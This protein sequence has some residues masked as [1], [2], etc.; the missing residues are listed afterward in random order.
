LRLSPDQLR[1]KIERPVNLQPREGTVRGVSACVFATVVAQSSVGVSGQGEIKHTSAGL[2]T[3]AHQVRQFRSPLLRP[4]PARPTHSAAGVALFSPDLPANQCERR[5]GSPATA[6]A[7]LEHYAAWIEPNIGA[8]KGKASVGRDAMAWY[9]LD[10]NC[11]RHTPASRTSRGTWQEPF[12]AIGNRPGLLGF[13]TENAPKPSKH[14][15]VVPKDHWFTQRTGGRTMRL[16]PI[17]DYQHSDG[18]GT[19]PK[20]RSLGGTRAQSGGAS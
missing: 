20:A 12:G 14:L 4:R 18:R 16:D 1:L 17:T 8:L 5:S 3:L 11:F 10:L 6:A 13:P 19:P 15:F 2:L 7:A 9:F